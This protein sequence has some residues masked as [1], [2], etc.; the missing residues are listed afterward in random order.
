MIKLTNIILIL[1]F[2]SM[3]IYAKDIIDYAGEGNLDAVT[4]LLNAGTDP[5]IER[6]DLTPLLAVGKFCQDSS[7]ATAT[8][9]SKCARVAS[10]LI[11]SGA[12]AEFRDVNGTTFFTRYR[13]ESSALKGCIQVV[14]EGKVHMFN[15]NCSLFKDSSTFQGWFN[16]N[17]KDVNGNTFFHL[18]AKFIQKHNYFDDCSEPSDTNYRCHPAQDISS[19]FTILFGLNGNEY[20][21]SKNNDELTPF[22]ALPQLLVVD[23]FKYKPK[24]YRQ[25]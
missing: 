14:S 7:Y 5:D 6:D 11:K 15:E 19:I 1:S 20:G 4:T 12:N 3:H 8:H 21:N 22:Y 16:P 25:R 13:L 2:S 17:T 9:Y 18:A 23:A 24:S 10:L